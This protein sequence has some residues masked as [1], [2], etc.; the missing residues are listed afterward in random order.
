MF[1]FACRNRDDFV[2]FSS[3]GRILF[4]FCDSWHQIYL[5][6]CVGSLQLRSLVSLADKIDFYRKY[7]MGYGK[8]SFKRGILHNSNIGWVFKLISP[9][10]EIY[11]HNRGVSFVN[12]TSDTNSTSTHL[13]YYYV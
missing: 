12:A 13:L 6:I 3:H 9:T 11:F 4:S 1:L 8:L 10:G 2:I 7:V 5:C